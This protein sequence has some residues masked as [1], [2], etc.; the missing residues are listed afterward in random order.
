MTLA[1]TALRLAVIEALSPFALQGASDPAW[2]TF[3]ADRV[4]DSTI[5]VDE[6]ADS[7]DGPRWRAPRVAVFVDE[8]KTEALGSAQDVLFDGDG[9]ERATLAFEIMVPAVVRHDDEVW[10]APAAGTDAMAEGFLDMIEEQIRQR[11]ADARMSAPLCLVLDRVDEVTSNPWRDADL[12]M[13]LSARRV[14][15]N[16]IVHQGAR[17]PD[18]GETGL[19]ALPS[20]LREVAR[21]LPEGSYG[22]NVCDTLAAALGNRA[23]FPALAE[24]R[25]AARF[26][27][28][29]G[30]APAAPPDA[31]TTPPKGDVAGKVTL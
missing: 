6:R 12:D 10:I 18:P 14:E 4:L 9:R 19:E 8:A 29:P 11:I 31:T 1:R 23:V 13:R 2:P 15:F 22:R 5:E 25:L 27:R 20:P 30:D 26:A 7:D 16:C 24:V 28:Q 17:W 3:A 21:A